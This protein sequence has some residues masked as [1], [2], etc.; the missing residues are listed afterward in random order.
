MPAVNSRQELAAF[1]EGRPLIQTLASASLE[2]GGVWT[3]E[4]QVL[5]TAKRGFFV[6]VI[7]LH[8]YTTCNGVAT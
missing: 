2:D 5:T 1:A 6:S 8:L 4:K 3:V 7:A